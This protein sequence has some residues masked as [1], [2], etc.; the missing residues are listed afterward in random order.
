[1]SLTTLFSFL[2]S[3]CIIVITLILVHILVLG[4]RVISLFVQYLK[5]LRAM[6]NI[7]KESHLLMERPRLLQGLCPWQSY[8]LIDSSDLLVL[9]YFLAKSGTLH[10]ISQT[11]KE[12]ID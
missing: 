1:M 5:I 4:F 2:T 9:S 7:L 6:S 12:I 3:S 8:L 10:K 11:I